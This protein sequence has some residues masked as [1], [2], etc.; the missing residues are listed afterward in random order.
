MV[1]LHLTEWNIVFVFSTY[2][3][4]L[5]TV[6]HSVSGGSILVQQYYILRKHH[7]HNEFVCSHNIIHSK[8]ACVCMCAVTVR[9]CMRACMCACMHVCVWAC[10][11]MCVRVRACVCMCMCVHA[12]VFESMHVYIPY[13]VL[14][15]AINI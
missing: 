7:Q 9:A 4:K 15:T 11:C 10:A 12:H 13:T 2:E 3:T 5:C 14:H 8:Q 1:G 6:L